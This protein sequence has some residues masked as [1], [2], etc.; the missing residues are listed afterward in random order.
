MPYDIIVLIGR[1][2]PF[3]L[4][5]ASLLSRALQL[6]PHVIVLLG[7]AARPRSI[8]NPWTT[9]ERAVM[10]Q[11]SFADDAHRI[12]CL[13]LKDRL[14]NDQ[15]WVQDVQ[16]AV[17][18]QAKQLLGDKPLKIGLI[19]Y[20]KD[21]S[22]YYLDMFPQWG[23]IESANVAGG[24][25]A[26][27]IRNYLFSA[28]AMDAVEGHW[29]QIEGAVP[30]AV[31]QFLR[32]FQHNPAFAQLV[33]E[34]QYVQQYKAA[35]A[36]APYPPTFVTADAVVIHSGHL[37]L[38]RRRAEPGKGLWALPGGFV[39][40][41]ETVFDA[42]I[43]ELREETRLKIPAPVLRG[44]L[45]A[46]RVFDYPDRSQ[47][48]RTI[49]HAFLFE[50]PSGDLP[51]VRGTDDAE[52]AKWFPLAQVREMDEAFFEDHGDIVHYFLGQL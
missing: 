11:H 5:H 24:I 16:A 37:L 14:Y 21:Q 47:R 31:Y 41:K 39:D 13:P 22:A 45:K 10:I 49:T 51:V 19:G 50:F 12:H 7:S 8:K 35:W 20:H 15:Q 32:S 6:A 33:R 27:D 42:A 23:L 25:S 9:A 46:E 18:Q 29:M 48:G 3:H 17:Q 34:Q 52:K 26:T 36:L 2:A 43:R 28:P 44:S 1:F 30:P 40:Q 4:G 38:I